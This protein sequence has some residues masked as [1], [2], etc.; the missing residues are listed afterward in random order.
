MD[1]GAEAPEDAGEFD[2]AVAAADDRDAGRAL[3]QV[4]EVIGDAGE[5]GAGNVGLVRRAASGDDDALGGD[6]RAAHVEPMGIDEARMR[7]ELACPGL[8]E[9]GFVRRLEA[10][11]LLVL[12]CDEAGPVMGAAGDVPAEAARVLRPA[13]IFRG[14]DHE[15][16]GHAADIDAGAAPE[17]F[18]GDADT[19]AVAS[20]DAG[21]ARAAG[22]AADDEEVEIIGH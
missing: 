14:L 13:A 8:L 16:L 11:D 7:L 21:A 5:R 1:L 4:E 22:A 6:G 12:G 19:G 20:G 18:L 15:L 9:H 3:G 2:G 10:G 17:A